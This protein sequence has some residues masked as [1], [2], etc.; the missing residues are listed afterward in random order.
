MSAVATGS[1][2]LKLAEPV[3]PA[4]D[5]AGSFQG[6]KAVRMPI[7]ISNAAAIPRMIVVT[8]NESRTLP[9]RW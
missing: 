6:A 3:A 1:I 7:T 8:E 5:R 9:P 2:G 4:A